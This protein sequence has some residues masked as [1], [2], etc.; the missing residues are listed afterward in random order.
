MLRQAGSKYQG[1]RN[2]TLLK[3]KVFFDEEALVLGH[4]KGTGRLQSLMGKIRVKLANGIEFKIGTGFSDADRKSPPKV[5]SVITFKFQETSESGTPRFPVFLRERGDVT[6][7]EV[8]AN[9]KTTQPKSEKVKKQFVMKRTHTLLYTTVPSREQSSGAKMVT[10]DDAVAPPVNPPAKDALPPCRYGSKCYQRNEAHLAQFSHPAENDELKASKKK[11]AT[12]K[13]AAGDEEEEQAKIPCRWG[14]GCYRTGEEHRAKY[15]HDAAD[16]VVEEED[17]VVAQPSVGKKA[18]SVESSSKKTAP[19]PP[20]TPP[21]QAGDLM[22]VSDEADVPEAELERAATKALTML[23]VKEEMSRQRTM[24][25][26]ND[27]ADM[28]G[29]PVKMVEISIKELARLRKLEAA[30]AAQQK[31]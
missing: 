25:L 5:G 1:G 28:Q 8:L 21:V 31:K 22:E 9:A 17:E 29:S 7:E 3:V 10:D 14:K 24:M 20:S 6:W 27:P 26:S 2:K 18:K 19:A 4:E 15:S 30:A 11:A 23:D 16:E 12:K 13:R